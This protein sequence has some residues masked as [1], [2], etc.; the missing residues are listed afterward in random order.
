MKI[1]KNQIKILQ[2]KIYNK[3]KIIKLTPMINLKNNKQK[4]QIRKKYKNK[5]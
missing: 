3:K 1:N 5:K 2:I 4:L